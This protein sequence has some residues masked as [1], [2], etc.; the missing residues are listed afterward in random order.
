MAH[1]QPVELGTANEL[2]Q[3]LLSYLLEEYGEATN[4]KRTLV[5]SQ[6]ALHA[7]LE[8]YPLY[9]KIKP[10][11]GE[12]LTTL[13]AH[14][15]S[16]GS[17]CLLC[18][19]YFR[20]EIIL[21]GEDPGNL[22]LDEREA[23]VVAYGARLAT[24]PNDVDEVLFSRLSA[25]FSDTEIVDL[26]AFAVLMIATNVFNS[27]LRVELDKPLLPY[28]VGAAAGGE[29]T[30]TVATPAADGAAA[31]TGPAATAPAGEEAVRG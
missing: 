9:R 31:A 3:R 13:Y 28:R 27:A 7:L 14:A 10:L 30:A 19:T 29:A 4:M 8:W 20:R 2:E 23:A 22:V 1:I 11:L 6:E 15:I 16:T 24:S 21:A 5:R 18:S 17:E 12:Q 25:Y 26:T